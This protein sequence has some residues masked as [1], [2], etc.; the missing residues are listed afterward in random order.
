M[1]TEIKGGG[2][3]IKTSLKQVQNISFLLLLLQTG[4]GFV[5]WGGGVFNSISFARVNSPVMTSE[6]ASRAAHEA[7]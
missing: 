2:K 6:R 3:R 4:F 1:N 7:W 5:L